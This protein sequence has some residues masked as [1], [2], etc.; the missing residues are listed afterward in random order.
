[1]N[2]YKPNFCFAFKGGCTEEDDI[3]YYELNF[4]GEGCESF[5][6]FY[7]YDDHIYSVSSCREIADLIL[8]EN[9]VFMPLHQ[10]SLQEYCNWRD[11]IY[12]CQRRII[13]LISSSS[14]V[15]NNE[16]R[17][18]EVRCWCFGDDSGIHSYDLYRIEEIGNEYCKVKDLV[19]FWLDTIHIE[20]CDSTRLKSDIVC[21]SYVVDEN[22]HREIDSLVKALISQ[23][24]A[25]LQQVIDSREM[26]FP[27]LQM[28]SKGN[29]IKH[30]PIPFRA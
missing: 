9:D 6:C 21:N 29:E 1:M 5:D 25:E 16:P 24:S 12:K 18:G 17:D 3:P 7:I 4:C 2:R 19:G 23:L 27:C 28:S 8:E 15:V 22:I 14:M 20:I 13:E 10:I 11:A 30:K 26:I